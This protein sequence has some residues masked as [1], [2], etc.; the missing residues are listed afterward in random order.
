VELAEAG[1]VVSSMAPAAVADRLLV[2][3]ES[4]LAERAAGDA[5][6]ERALRLLRH[7]R[8]AL[9]DGDEVRA[10]RRALYALQLADGKGGPSVDPRDGSDH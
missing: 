9:A 7:A 6:A 5:D 10:L 1:V 3:A 2:H 8:E 4:R